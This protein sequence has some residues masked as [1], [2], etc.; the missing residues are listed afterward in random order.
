[1]KVR[2]ICEKVERGD[3][4]LVC[5]GHQYNDHLKRFINEYKT[6]LANS[7]GAADGK[8]ENSRNE[9]IDLINLRMRNFYSNLLDLE[10]QENESLSYSM[11]P[12]KCFGCGQS[13]SWVLSGNSLIPRQYYKI[14]SGKVVYK[15]HSAGY[16]CPYEDPKP[17]TG[18]IEINS[19]MIFS[20][21]FRG[22]EDCPDRFKYTDEWSLN[23]LIGRENITKYK[24]ERNI[25]YGQM[26]NMSIGVYVNKERTSIIIGPSYNPSEWDDY[27][28]EEDYEKACKEPIFE[29]YELIGTISCGVWRWECSDLNTVKN[30]YQII[31]DE[32]LDLVEIDVPYGKWAFEHYYGYTQEKGY[33]YSKL[34][35][36][37]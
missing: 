7:L 1:M 9:D 32:G 5:A 26:E 20:N 16:R 8:W 37:Q 15:Q 17:L 23:F 22:F 29:N 33:I 12:I 10:V 14:R 13:L 21:Y 35:L 11:E 31:L 34:D 30:D 36:V 4:V 2:D 6:K 24:A 19:K 25:A 28:S 27:E 18:E 3:I